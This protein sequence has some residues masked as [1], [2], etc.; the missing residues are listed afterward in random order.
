MNIYESIKA[1]RSVEIHRSYVDVF[2]NNKFFE[3]FGDPSREDDKQVWFDKYDIDDDH[4]IK[5][6]YHTRIGEYE[7][8]KT[9]KIDL[10]K[11]H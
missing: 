2:V 4:T 11:H 3:R 5:V 1:L 6:H 7:I 10:K 8:C 9:F